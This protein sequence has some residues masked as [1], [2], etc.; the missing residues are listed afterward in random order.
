M[1][2][3]IPTAAEFKARYPAF[4]DVDDALIDAVIAEAARNVD[5]SWCEA[6]Y[7]PAIMAL[8]AHMLIE[9]GALG[10]NVEAAGPITSS[11]LGDAQDSY[12][13]L[14]TSQASGEYSSTSYGRKYMQ[15]R[16][17]N[18]QGVQLL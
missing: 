17:V 14:S 18:C 4:T 10:R 15:L 2:Y 11:K 1:P 7:Q 3:V 9:E 6:D 16:A 8:T 12:G 13:G 5:E